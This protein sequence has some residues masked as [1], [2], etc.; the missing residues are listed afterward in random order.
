MISYFIRV[1]F[2]EN[3]KDW[4]WEAPTWFKPN[5]F[6]SISSWIIAHFEKSIWIKY[7]KYNFICNSDQKMLDFL[8]KTN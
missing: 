7:R 6:Q 5:S 2:D 8:M 1:V 4:I 3:L